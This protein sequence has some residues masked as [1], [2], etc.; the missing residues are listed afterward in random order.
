MSQRYYTIKKV[1]GAQLTAEMRRKLATAWNGY[2]NSSTTIS[3]RRF[4]GI[5]GL[6]RSTWDRELRRGATGPI[7]R[8]GNKWTYP[9]YDPLKAMDSINEG[10]A[11]M[12]TRMK[13]TTAMAILFRYLVLV[14][15]RSPYDAREFIVD[16]LPD[17]DV[18]CLRTFYNHVYAGDTGVR[19]GD[20]PYHPG[21]KRR[22]KNPPH[23][24]KTVP[25]R[26]T[27]ADRPREAQERSELGHWEMDTVVSAGHR[28]GLL[29]LI[30]RCSRLYVIEYIAHISQDAVLLALRRMLK[31]GAL[32]I[33][34][35][36]TT[37][38]G[39]EFINPRKL[40]RLMK[41]DIY[42]TRAYAA[43]EKGSVENA[44]RLVRRF[45]PK[46]TRFGQ[47]SK[48]QIRQLENFINSIHRLSLKGESANEYHSRL[49]KA[50]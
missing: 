1:Q 34:R 20:T 33:V 22:P 48:G 47:L 12:G 7:L 11:N 9:E 35:S 23:P 21:W 27:L 29:V 15:H 26:L 43:W 31:R 8:R 10:K 49:A 16:A 25:G 17:A 5:H 14:Q 3:I 13:M 28:D 44:N 41:T 32:G 36:I 2:V 4:A 24:A 6:S 38:N 18:P 50:A 40:Q 42:Y 37:D 45:Y 30:D 39:C 19:Y 46:G